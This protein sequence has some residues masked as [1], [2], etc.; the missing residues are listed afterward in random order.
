MAD[1]NRS[2]ID[3]LVEAAAVYPD[4][5]VEGV[6]SPKPSR[7]IAVVACMDARLDLFALLGLST[8]DCHVIRNAGGVIT[9]DVVRSL[10]LSQRALGTREV[11]LIHHTDCGLEK[12]SEDT[13][14]AELEAETGQRPGWALMDFTDVEQDVRESLVR[15]R[16]DAFLQHTDAIRG[17]V[18][19]V[20][21]GKLREVS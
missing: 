3:E 21:S 5:Y 7:R 18:F 1:M 8:G 13:F 6:H 15:L 4:N 10:V 14:F 19:D 17:F 16:T 2:V 20:D 12:V 11:I 9:D